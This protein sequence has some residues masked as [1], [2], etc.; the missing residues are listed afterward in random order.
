MKG[1]I[2]QWVREL[3]R[4]DGNTRIMFEMV[5]GSNCGNPF[6]EYCMKYPQTNHFLWWKKNKNKNKKQAERT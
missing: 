3:A 1:S 4:G 2:F 5:F 6:L